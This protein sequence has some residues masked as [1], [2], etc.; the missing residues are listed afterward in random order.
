MPASNLNT[1][2]LLHYLF[3]VRRFTPKKQPYMR[4]DTTNVDGCHKKELGAS[5]NKNA[6]GS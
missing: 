5:A 3:P 4:M 1:Y 2:F 6:P